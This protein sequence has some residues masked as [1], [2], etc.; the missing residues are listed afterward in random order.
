MKQ[1]K[2]IS[3]TFVAVVVVLVFVISMTNIR[4]FAT[5][6][7]KPLLYMEL[8]EGQ[9]ISGE[10]IKIAL[11]I[12]SIHPFEALRYIIYA[13]N[14]EFISANANGLQGIRQFDYE[15]YGDSVIFVIEIY[16]GEIKPDK[17]FTLGYVDIKIKENA[18]L[19]DDVDVLYIQNHEVPDGSYYESDDSRKILFGFDFRVTGLHMTVIDPTP[20]STPT[21]TK[22]P[23]AKPTDTPKP[24][25]AK[26]TDTPKPSTPAPTETP[27]PVN[28]TETPP[29]ETG[30]LTPEPTNLETKTPAISDKT[31]AITKSPEPSVPIGN[32]GDDN[33]DI[34]AYVFWGFVSII[35]GMWAGIGI[36]YMIWGKRSKKS[37]FSYRGRY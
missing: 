11:K 4:Q 15:R 13:E 21:P 36:G 3:N 19:A 31:P 33:I 24:T 29:L 17:P 8:V 6:D 12:D 27:T 26:P 37:M 23:T 16:P 20:T 5:Q 7:A 34:W 32:G 35:I 2:G 10:N 9:P 1:N 30:D 25:T 22:E 14:A 18:K 28:E